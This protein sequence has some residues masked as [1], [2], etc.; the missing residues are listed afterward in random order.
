MHT[1]AG[2]LIVVLLGRL[3]RRGAGLA[4]RSDRRDLRGAHR[5]RRRRLLD[6]HRR[7]PV[8]AAHRRAELHPRRR[9]RQLRRQEGASRSART[10]IR[11]SSRRRPP[12]SKP[13]ARSSTLSVT[14][15]FRTLAQ[16]YLLYKWYQ[17]GQC[18]ISLAA[19]PGNSNHETGIAV[20]LGNYSSE[21]GNMSSHG[22]THSYPS[23]DPVHFDY[24]AGGTTDLRS[25]SVLAFQKLW[26][27]NNPG[28][29]IAEDGAYGPMTGGEDRG[30]AGDRLRQGH[31]LHAADDAA[32]TRRRDAQFAAT[33]VDQSMPQALGAGEIAGGVGRVREHRHGDVGAGHDAARHHRSA[34]S[35][36][37]RCRRPIGSRRTAPPPST[38]RP[39][40]ARSGRF[41]FSL[42]R[43]G[44]VVAPSR[45][46]STSGWCRRAWPGSPTRRRSRST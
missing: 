8:Q 30:V 9:A 25:E 43:A 21:I 26:N 12:G 14:S 36:Q 15:A 7:R 16:Q 11:T 27:L 46:P 24:T 2:L 3:Q 1:R 22:W 18:G 10:S 38:P 29:K 33:L 20:D 34:G 13:P 39:S 42:A 45:S 19:V 32:A 31:D 44:G 6:L 23:S 4:R 5:R 37:R 41:S 35:R 40:P 17:N 28:A